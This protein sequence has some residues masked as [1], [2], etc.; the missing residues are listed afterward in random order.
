MLPRSCRWL[1]TNCFTEPQPSSKRNIYHEIYEN[2]IFF[3]RKS[4]SWRLDFV[5]RDCW[6]GIKIPVE[7]KQCMCYIL[8]R[9]KI[10]S[11]MIYHMK[12]KYLQICPNTLSF[13][14]RAWQTSSY[15]PGTLLNPI[16]CGGLS[17]PRPHQ[18]L[19]IYCSR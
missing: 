13:C 17:C 8:K 14:M 9:K 15:S 6:F 3:R 16:G 18:E 5:L 19:L 4:F 7:R 1:D 2:K 11:I 12:G 10:F